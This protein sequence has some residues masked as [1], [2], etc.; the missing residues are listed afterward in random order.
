MT[1]LEVLR[2]IHDMA[3]D[4]FPILSCLHLL[5]QAPGLFSFIFLLL[6]V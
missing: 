5:V 4:F 6:Y 2:A 1:H 3:P